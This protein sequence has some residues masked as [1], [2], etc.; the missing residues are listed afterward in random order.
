MDVHLPLGILPDLVRKIRIWTSPI[1]IMDRYRPPAK[2]DTRETQSLLSSW[3]EGID[4]YN[5]DDPEEQALRRSYSVTEIYYPW[6]AIRCNTQSYE[7]HRL[8]AK[9]S[10]LPAYNNKLQGLHSS[11]PIG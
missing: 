6:S 10:G 2:D 9:R 3:T 8:F 11:G 7:G 1:A 4:E 5:S